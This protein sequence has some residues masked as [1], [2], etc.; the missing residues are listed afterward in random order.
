M[1]LSLFLYEGIDHILIYF[2]V[3][4]SPSYPIQ[5]EYKIY[6][7]LLGL[8]GQL[9]AL[10]LIS[11]SELTSV[12]FVSPISFKYAYIFAVPIYLYIY[13]SPGLSLVSEHR[14]Q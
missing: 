8:K 13:L 6:L 5:C 4:S 3:L 7:Y 11:L 9:I 14:T 1:F 10:L 12:S 2:V